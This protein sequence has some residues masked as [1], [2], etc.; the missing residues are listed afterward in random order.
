M[1]V[2]SKRVTSILA[3]MLWA[4]GSGIPAFADD[5]ELF[6]SV[7]GGGGNVRPN[8][9]FIID[10]SGSMNAEVLTQE[11]YDPAVAYGG[12]CSPNE[13]YWRS[14]TGNPP[15]CGDDEW[16]ER[17]ALMCDVA[18]QAFASG[19]GTYTDV[20]AQYDSNQQIR[21]EAIDIDG[22]TLLVEC[23]D[24]RGA[25]GDGISGTELYA[26]DLTPSQPWSADPLAEVPWGLGGTN[27]TYTVYDSN[28]LNWYYGPTST[29][30]R[31]Q[32]VKDVTTN[33]L[34]SINGVNV[35]LM[36]F[37]TS[38]GGAVIYAIE[39]IATARAGLVAAIDSL[40]AGGWTP[41]SE[42]HYEAA[43][44]YMG[45]SVDYGD[46]EGP[47]NSVVNSRVVGNT[48]VYNSPIEYGCQK[49]MIVLLTD[50]EP[51]QD[52]GANNK[53]KSLPNYTT[54]VGA[55]CDPAG[56]GACL[57]DMAEYLFLADLD[58]N[59]P[60]VQNVTTYTIGGTIDLPILATTAARGGG[61]YYLAHD[62]ASL[63]TAL[64][65]IVTAILNTNTTFTA[66]AVAVN[67]FNRTQNR[68]D[69]FISLF[70]SSGEAHWPG[71]LKKYRLRAAD[72][73]LV[74]ANGAVAVDPATGFFAD[75]A[76]SYWSAVV[77]GAETT[78][79]GA[80]NLLPDP[81]ARNVYTY[82]VGT[83]MGMGGGNP[84]LSAASNIV[85]S[86]NLL[87]DDALLGIGQ[88]G[89]PTRSDLIDFIRGLDVTDIDQDTIVAEPRYQMGDP[90]H[91]KPAN[92]I[93]GGTVA[94]PDINDAVI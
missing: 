63:S 94:N 29:S 76:Q 58:P 80:A 22:K 30:T 45:S 89:D 35:G 83:G 72:G 40:S 6:V 74:D 69:I 52:T 60:G 64:T 16:F 55:K 17:T 5:T 32:V 1:S 37:N 66:P 18:I 91:A 70:E 36:R 21:W 48:G 71:N 25:H 93:Y 31:M 43:L 87:I 79:G 46:Q 51:T 75:T 65:E 38:E 77:D 73:V 34:N 49:N 67:S 14:G 90:L 84:D 39:N 59:L 85:V 23:E 24:D 7:A 82:T 8:V 33:L 27:G 41:L 61:E 62:T 42:T 92:I 19:A 28:Y 53:V 81:V 2:T 47:P 26:T 13:V 11:T 12:G 9:L 56:Q 88:V 20:M 50:G 15:Q 54:L 3:G 68:N 78:L 86:T 10:T 57:N 44:Y 4:L